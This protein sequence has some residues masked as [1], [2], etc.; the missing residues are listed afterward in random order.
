M[1]I[2]SI[3]DTFEF[4]DYINVDKHEIN[5]LPEGINVSTMCASCKLN[6]RL[7]IP[8]I[9]QYLQLNQD[10]ILIVKKNKERIR[11]IMN[12]KNKPKRNKKNEIKLKDTTKN[13]FYNQITVVVRVSHGYV[14]DLDSVSKINIK[15]FKNGSVQMSGCKSINS[16]NIVLNKLIERLKEVKAKIE[17][18][19][20]IEKSFI[21]DSN[22]IKV[23]DFKIDMINSNYQVVMQIDRDKLH[24][25]LLKKKIKSSYEP[26]IRACVI[27]KYCPAIDNLE[28]KEISVFIF[29][30]G[31]VIITGAR[32]KSHIISSYNY[33]NNILLTHKDEINKKDEKEEEDL[34]FELYNDLMKDIEI[35]IVKL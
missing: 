14:K 6:T 12:L 33:I 5:N 29:Q 20:I 34:L 10:D 25:L 32:S 11:S 28:N 18:G 23:S 3:W 15:L 2:K 8:N 26:C 7:N 19:V 31:N 9:E 13:H 17:N 24:N 22:I 21:E 35:G 30:K 1:S 27:L 4:T 16:I